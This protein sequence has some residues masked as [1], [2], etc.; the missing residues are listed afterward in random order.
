MTRYEAMNAIYDVI[1]SGILDDEHE[2]KLTE[3]V[4]CICDGGFEICPKECL[5]FC[6][7]DE[8]ENAEEWPDVT[9]D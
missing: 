9:D 5:R 7:K 3:V 1:N 4:N 6:K 8:C 2:E